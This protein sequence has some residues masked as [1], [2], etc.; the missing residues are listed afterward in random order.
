LEESKLTTVQRLGLLR[1]Q[2][3]GLS[4][5]RFSEFEATEVQTQAE[6]LS[7]ER[8]RAFPKLKTYTVFLPLMPSGVEH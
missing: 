7:W 5:A 2:D 3:T 1:R 6:N 8:V 4:D